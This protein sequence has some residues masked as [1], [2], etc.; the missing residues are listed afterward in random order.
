MSR[1]PRA[2]TAFTLVE[3]LVVIAIIA[4]LIG[5]LLPAVQKIREAAA[6]TQCRNNLKQLGLAAHNYHDVNHSLPPG[7]LG[8]SPVVDNYAGQPFGPDT[9][10]FGWPGQFVGVLFYLL[11]YIEQANLQT[12]T[13][14]GMPAE[15]FNPNFNY[16]PWWT[17]YGTWAAAQNRVKTFECPA[18]DPYS[19]TVGTITSN[20]LMHYVNGEFFQAQH[21]ID[22]NDGGG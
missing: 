19:N 13:V 10:D 5:L 16:G 14:A 11:P 15:Y 8:T 4:I 22:L 1:L 18:D 2:R 20:H 12:Q 9:W 3:L 17:C 6:R 7:W 21:W